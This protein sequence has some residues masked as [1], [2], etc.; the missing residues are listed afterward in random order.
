MSNER[1]KLMDVPMDS[2]RLARYAV[3]LACYVC[4]CENSLD[5]ELCRRCQAPLALARQ[6]EGQK[7][8][9]QLLAVIGS[10]GAG[11]TVYLS[12]LIDMLS[13]RSSGLRVLA[14]GAF[15]INLQ[16]ATIAALRRCQFPEKTPNDPDRWH[17]VHCQVEAPRRRRPLDVIV[18][19]VAGE[20]ILEEIDHPHTYPAI[21]ALLAKAAGAL[22]LLD[23]PRLESSKSGQDL[24]ALKLLEGFCEMAD[25][26][27]RG[28]HNRPVAVVFTKSD[29]CDACLT[30]PV[31][32]A[33][34][35]LPAVARLCQQRMRRHQF[36]ACGVAGAC[37]R[38]VH[39]LDGAIDVPLRIEPRGVI[40]PFE[41]LLRR[42]KG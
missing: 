19:D 13:R 34:H 26:A 37:A 1:C 20:S 17:W 4:E 40:E 8:R 31:A 41:W 15:S 3:P 25:P 42:V 29:Q 5:D 12:M 28:W 24:F 35:R 10:S 14:R 22:V 33:A 32:Y 38:Q 9:P 36:F 23:G 7:V 6:A 18:P 21:R 27:H 16:Q 39:G 2:Y 30:D 11:K